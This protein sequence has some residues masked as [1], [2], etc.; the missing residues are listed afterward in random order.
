M[1][2]DDDFFN[3]LTMIL[4]LILLSEFAIGVFLIFREVFKEYR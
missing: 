1:K 2:K 3:D 4:I